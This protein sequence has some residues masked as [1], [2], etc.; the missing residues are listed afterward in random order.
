MLDRLAELPFWQA[1][2]AL[3]ASAMVRS[4]GTYWVGRGAI[5]GWRR[6]RGAHGDLTAR[7]ERLL[8]RFGP[9]AV[10]LSY[11]TVGIQTA[12]HLTAGVMRM[13]LRW[14]VPAAV[15]GSVL[16]AV[17][18]ATIGIA[19]VQAWLAAEAGSWW[20]VAVVAAALV[21]AVVWV[22]VRRRSRRE[23][24]LLVDAELPRG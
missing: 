18:Y 13:P 5:A 19:V 10:T 7:A 12:I 1:F 6:Y 3:F 8:H 20:G 9:F 15:V 16:W 17:L 4:N 11:L 22:V 14:Y 2:L 23:A 21:A 24:G